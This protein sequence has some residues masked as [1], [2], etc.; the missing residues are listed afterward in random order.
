M[1]NHRHAQGRTRSNRST[2]QTYQQAAMTKQATAAR[3]LSLHCM[4]TKHQAGLVMPANMSIAP[5]TSSHA[6]PSGQ[7]QSVIRML[8][9]SDRIYIEKSS[10]GCAGYGK[11]TK[12]RT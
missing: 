6:Q 7:S 3:Y 10:L 12:S 4:Q 9:V 2:A 1:R 11:A 5:H 8:S